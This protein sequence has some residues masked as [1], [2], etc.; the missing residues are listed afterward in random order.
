MTST[1]PTAKKSN[2]ISHTVE[3]LEQLHH[4]LD[5][6]ERLLISSLA[7]LVIFE[8]VRIHLIM[9][10]VDGIVLFIMSPS[11]SLNQSDDNDLVDINSVEKVQI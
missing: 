2:M 1:G 10:L 8:T 11:L 7:L 4:F 3:G 5:A 9:R 6:Q